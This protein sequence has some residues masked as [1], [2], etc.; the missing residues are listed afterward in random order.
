MSS[1][2]QKKDEK[3]TV[4]S[5]RL[6]KLAENYESWWESAGSVCWLQQRGHFLAKYSLRF[7]AVQNRRRRSEYKGLKCSL[8]LLRH[9]SGVS[10][11]DL[12]GDRA[13]GEF[14]RQQSGYRG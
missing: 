5:K 8:R 12:T 7:R 4:F 1:H 2:Q 13:A 14:K 6:H 9:S 10:Q 11:R 3:S